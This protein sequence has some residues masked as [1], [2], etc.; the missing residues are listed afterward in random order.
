M[1]PLESSLLHQRSVMMLGHPNH[2]VS[3]D[4]ESDMD[5]EDWMLG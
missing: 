4:A 2:P 3:G 5:T 1:R